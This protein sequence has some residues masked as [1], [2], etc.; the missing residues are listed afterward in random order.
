MQKKEMV[1]RSEGDGQRKSFIQSP[2]GS[3][4]TAGYRA[5]AILS[6]IIHAS[7]GNGFARKTFVNSIEKL[8]G[9][10]LRRQKGKNKGECN[11]VSTLGYYI[12]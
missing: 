9:V 5:R 7:S 10:A 4:A 3:A 11:D 2:V 12:I 8:L 1:L 6:L